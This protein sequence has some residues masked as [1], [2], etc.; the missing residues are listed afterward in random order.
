MR[1]KPKG[2][3]LDDLKTTHIINDNFFVFINVTNRTIVF[4]QYI[5]N[6]I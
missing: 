2:L 5:L 6:L 3:I 4:N 1:E